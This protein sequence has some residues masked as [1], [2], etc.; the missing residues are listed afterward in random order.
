M[1]HFILKR[2]KENERDRTSVGKLAGYLGLVSNVLLFVGKLLIGL[3]AQ[4]VS[5]MADAINSLS[6]SASSVL[7]LVGFRIA[8]KPADRE[9][10]YGHE[11]FEYISGFVVS[12]LM[13]FVGFQ[14]LKNSFEK[15]I[16]P[17]AIRLSP[18]L[19]IILLLSIGLKLWQ[20]RM[21]QV[22]AKKIDSATLQASGQDSFN[23]V[24]TTVA[25]LFSALIEWGTGWRIDGY[26]GLIIAIFILYSGIKMIRTFINELLGARPT[27]A[28]IHEMELRLDHYSSI[29][30]YH[31]LL[32]HSYGPKNRFASVHIEVNE[33]WSLA[34]AHEVIDE[35]EQDFQKNLHVELVCHPDPVP[36]QS[37]W[38]RQLREQVRQIIEEIDSELRM[39]DFRVQKNQLDFD[40]VIPK[41]RNYTDKE[42]QEKVTQQVH[43][44]IGEYEVMIT[45]D[46]IYLL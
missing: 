29:L 21:Y 38:Y 33:N 31:D 24:L 40:L 44:R 22:L 39:H 20:G 34:Q 41:Q 26:V 14:F 9:H 43:Q 19:F 8:A 37:K 30:G 28:E 13:M 17:E 23:D 12:L 45:F 15:I 27:E 16:N 6:D 35:I 10:P 11:R 25:V 3:S 36:I 42:L 5:I 18:W 4:S 1:L 7:T 46:H 32:I 2:L